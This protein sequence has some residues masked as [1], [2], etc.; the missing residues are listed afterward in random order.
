MGSD[1]APE[2]G[3]PG[4][5]SSPMSMECG[6]RAELHH[7]VTD[8]DT[9]ASLRSGDVAVLGTPKVVALCEEV[10]IQAIAGSLPPGH[11]TVGMRVQIEHLQPTAVGI[12]VVA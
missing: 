5:T 4:I 1:M 12:E 10:A 2:Y 8:A 6:V 7:V 9:A 3:Q 11:T